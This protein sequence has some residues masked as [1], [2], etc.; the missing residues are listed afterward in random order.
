MSPSI[1]DTIPNQYINILIT[2]IY[3]SLPPHLAK[4]YPGYI[5]LLNDT[6]D[7]N[8]KEDDCNDSTDTSS[9]EK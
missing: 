2:S 3:P 1:K 5:S 7:S 8:I 9:N 6:H 4:Y